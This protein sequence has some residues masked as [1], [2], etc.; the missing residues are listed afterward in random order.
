MKTT[1]TVAS[2]PPLTAG[3]QEADESNLVTSTTNEI[4]TT[5][6]AASIADTRERSLIPARAELKSARD[7]TRPGTTIARSP[8]AMAEALLPMPTQPQ[9]PYGELRM[10]ARAFAASHRGNVDLQAFSDMLESSGFAYGDIHHVAS[11]ARDLLANSGGAQSAGDVATFDAL[12]TA[13]D[14]AYF[15]DMISNSVALV[16]LGPHTSLVASTCWRML[17]EAR[18]KE[19]AI[20]PSAQ[21]GIFT[22]L[23][24]KLFACGVPNDEATAFIR[25]TRVQWAC[26]TCIPGSQKTLSD[27]TGLPDV[28]TMMVPKDK[29]RG[30]LDSFDFAPWARQLA[31]ALT[32]RRQWEPFLIKL[33]AEVDQEKTRMR[34]SRCNLN[35]AH[36]GRTAF[37]SVADRRLGLKSEP[38]GVLA[39]SEGEAA[40]LPAKEFNA[41][42]EKNPFFVDQGAEGQLHGSLPHVVHMLFVQEALQPQLTAPNAPALRDLVSMM[43]S[44]R[45][46]VYVPSAGASGQ[47]SLWA[48]LFDSGPRL[49]F[50]TSAEQLKKH[51][52]DKINTANGGTILSRLLQQTLFNDHPIDLVTM[53]R[54]T[55]SLQRRSR[56]ANEYDRKQTVPAMLAYDIARELNIVTS[57]RKRFRTLDEAGITRALTNAGYD[58]SAIQKPRLADGRLDRDEWLRRIADHTHVKGLSAQLIRLLA[59]TD[60]AEP[61][62][63]SKQ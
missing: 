3:S 24:S 30:G 23:A 10:Q 8:Q 36:L 38:L 39:P 34:S 52:I 51:E 7:T 48:A 45:V 60:A 50:A 59:S 21:D 63:S 27:M 31:L 22:D 61:P 17:L 9:T 41:F 40:L 46:D 12:V 13:Y 29:L 53:L 28:E 35:E 43:M 54:R 47:T 15:H 26:D 58:P 32:N 16:A 55:A 11:R 14:H 42:V 62:S 1:T 20:G 4:T 25:A 37:L 2:A 33:W 44:L 18:S 5:Y 49:E 57:I 19:K 56:K 6:L